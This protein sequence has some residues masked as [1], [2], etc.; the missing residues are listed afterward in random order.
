MIRRICYIANP[1]W[2]H[3]EKWARWFAARDGCEL[4]MISEI[5]PAYDGVVW[6]PLRIGGFHG[7]PWTVRAWWEYRRLFKAMRPS[8]VHI[9]N[10]E[11][12]ALPAALAWRGPLVITTY[13]LDVTRFHQCGGSWRGLVAK[14]YLLRRADVV[15]AASKFLVRRTMEIGGLSEAKVQVTPFGVDTGHFIPLISS[16]QSDVVVIGMP[17]DLK[18]EYAPLD[19]VRAFSLLVQ[20]GRRVRG[21]IQGRGPQLPQVQ[22][23]IR[24]SGLDGIL[25]VRDRMPLESMPRVYAEMDICVLPSLQESFGVAALEAQSMG[26]PVVATSVEG[27]GEVL[28]H[29]LTGFHVPAANPEALADSLDT[30]IRDPELRRTMGSAGRRFVTEHYDWQVTVKIMERIYADLMSNAGERS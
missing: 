4:H 13:G 24:E 23:A 2:P 6:H 10:L 28:I 27:L 22:A 20:R 21:F 14:R 15:T 16:K 3:V 25:E 17:K 1:N 12:G 7:V 11:Y 18:P 9:H 8:L 30:L 29:G 26:V 5:K 19:F